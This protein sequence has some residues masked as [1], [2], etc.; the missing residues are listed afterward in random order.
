MRVGVI[1]AGLAG[2]VAAR[3][4]AAVGA[5]VQ[6][7]DKARGPSGRMATRRSDDGQFDHGAP[8]FTVRDARFAHQVEA[9]Q[10]LGCV[11]R[12]DARV[13]HLGGGVARPERDA[14]ERFVGLPRMSAIGRALSDG[15]DVSYGVRVARIESRNGAW[16]LWSDADFEYGDF[17]WVVLATPAPQATPLL[18]RTPAC[19]RRPAAR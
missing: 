11:A 7:F 14:A 3:R 8:A 16:V 12:W 1:G 19:A 9:W 17:D 6:L 4:L 10:R 15:L 18:W 5:Q 2:L 13:V